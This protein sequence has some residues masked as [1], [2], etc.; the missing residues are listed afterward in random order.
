MEETTKAAHAAPRSTGITPLRLAILKLTLSFLIG[1][2]MVGPFLPHLVDRKSE[3][4]LEQ[5]W[6][7]AAIAS[8]P[9]YLIVRG[10]LRL[11]HWR[12]TRPTSHRR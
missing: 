10:F 8:V 9:G 12:R 4:A 2:I 3:W 1:L 11:E 6:A 5:L 7:W